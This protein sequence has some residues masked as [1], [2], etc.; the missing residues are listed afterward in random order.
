ML[1]ETSY[2]HHFNKWGVRRRIRGTEKEDI[3]AA[4]GRRARPETS[5]SQVTLDSDKAVDKK[6]MK[7]YLKDQ[8]RHHNAQPISPG[9]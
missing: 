8:I 6:Q 4:L 5:T 2:R 7:R 9:V 1:R 3:V